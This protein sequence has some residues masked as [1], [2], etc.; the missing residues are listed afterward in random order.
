MIVRT[1]DLAVQA[2]IEGLRVAQVGGGKAAQFTVA[3][4]GDRSLYGAFQVAL[5]KGG[6]AKQIAEIRG[7]GVYPEIESRAITIPLPDD[8]ALPAGARLRVSYID[9]DAK[10]GAV[11]AQ[12]EVAVP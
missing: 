1:G 4:S 10:P 12:A 8:V 5:V 2:Q 7:V 9:D 3:R 6:D 11:L